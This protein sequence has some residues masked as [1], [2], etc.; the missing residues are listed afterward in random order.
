MNRF[1]MFIVLTLIIS[2]CEKENNDSLFEKKNIRNVSLE[3]PADFLLKKS[4]SD[5]TEVY[6]IFSNEKLIGSMYWGA[7]YKPFVEDYSITNEKEIYRKVHSAGTKIYYSNYA[8][9]DY[10][11]GVFNDN[12]YYY[13]TINKS[14]AQVMLPKKPNKGLIGIYFDS[15][16]IRKNKFAIISNDLSEENKNK[17]L[18]MFKTIKIG[19]ATQ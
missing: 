4:Q 5:D 16:D 17:F 9:Q 11:N 2:S 13:D 8:E 10:K 1:F 6:N 18:R 14:I 15:V 3:I 19:K 12:Y 7:Y